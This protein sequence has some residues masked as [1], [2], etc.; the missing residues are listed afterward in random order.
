MEKKE[1]AGSAEHE[2]AIDAARSNLGTGVGERI[3]LACCWLDA[4]T[5][6]KSIFSSRLQLCR[7]GIRQAHMFQIAFGDSRTF[8][9]RAEEVKYWYHG[10]VGV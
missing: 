4:E 10:G 9:N 7:H 1:A 8:I 6:H 3:V 5:G 2:S